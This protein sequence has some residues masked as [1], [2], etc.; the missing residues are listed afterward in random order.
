MNKMQKRRQLRPCLYS[1]FILHPSSLLGA[2]VVLGLLLRAWFYA[3]TPSVWHDEAALLVNA[4][5]KDFSELLGPLYLA[6]AAPPLFLAVTRAVAVVL[7]DGVPLLRLVPFAASCAA[8]LLVAATARRTVGVKAAAWA[9]LLFACSDRLLWHACEVK[10]YA[11]D[12]FAAAGLAFLHSR[13]MAL[14]RRLLLLAGLAPVVIFLC[15][16]GCFLFGG[17][18]VALLPAVWR[19]R[20]SASWLAY[21]L[22]A[23]AV[24]AAFAWLTLGP[25]RAQ[26]CG[27]LE[28]CWV[29]QFADWRRPL[30]VPVWALLSSL[31]VVDY[32]CRL[33]GPLL[34]GLAVL[35]GV[36]TWRAGRRSFVALLVMPVGLALVA[37]CLGKYPYGGSRVMAY[38]APAVLLLVGAGATTA[39]AWLGQ[40]LRLVAVV[41]VVVLLVPVPL[42]LYRAANPWQRADCGGAAAH[43]LARLR[44]GDGVVS[45]HWEYLYYFRRLGSTATMLSEG[46]GT[47]MVPLTGRARYRMYQ[48]PAQR[49]SGRLW[50][51]CTG[52]IPAEDRLAC[53]RGMAVG[54]GR[55]VEQWEFAATTVLLCVRAEE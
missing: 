37:A 15:F 9:T 28:E 46:G 55:V 30:H 39:L 17:V 27:P 33:A 44:P 31:D 51:V 36:Q 50:V 41:L 53:A 6:E 22:L 18:L 49:P 13:E 16:P 23:L 19:A 3:L 38:A 26:R 42:A 48:G 1:S 24:F 14:T 21:G 2:A 4:L 25:V 12:A 7:G 45:N 11:V 8:L 43:V 5:G 52:A 47:S 29:N 20:R 54:A 35:G 10:P 32:S 40:R 34:A